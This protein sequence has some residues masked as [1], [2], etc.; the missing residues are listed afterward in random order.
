MSL[1]REILTDL[2]DLVLLRCLFSSVSHR[3]TSSAVVASKKKMPSSVSVS[4]GVHALPQDPLPIPLINDS[5]TFENRQLKGLREM[6]KQTETELKLKRRE[7][8]REVEKMREEFLKLHR[9]D[10]VWGS[11]ELLND[12]LVFKRRGSTDI[13]NSK[14]MKTLIT[15][16]PDSD[17]RKFRLRFDL[18]GFD[19]ES[20]RVTS[21][22]ER[23]IV[24]A[25]KSEEGSHGVAVKKEYNRKIQKP[26]DVEATRLKSRLTSD[27]IM[28]V[29]API[30][31]KVHPAAG[32]AP[33]SRKTGPSP[34]HSFHGSAR[35]K[36][37]SNT[38]PSPLKELKLGIPTFKDEENGQRRLYLM[39][40][41]GKM[42]K[43]KDITIQVIKENRILIKAKHEER[44]SER[45][46][47]NKFSKEFE[48]AEK[49]EAHSIRGG[50][51]V[52]G[53]LIVGA[54]VKGF[55]G[56]FTKEN[57]GQVIIEVIDPNSDLM[58]C[59]ILNLASFPPTMSASAV[60]VQP[61]G[62]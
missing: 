8:E 19:P 44:T 61:N 1:G 9:S 30:G 27:G 39:I 12:P 38:P 53:H 43:P 16:N 52:D 45:L 17:H 33:S 20:V 2:L 35:S 49:I 57:A 21:D 4:S 40:D 5:L 31:S 37:P 51:T 29:E 42:F 24:R 13:L 47:K 11:D 56:E 58:P 10:R 3:E 41:I 7:L 25:T 32:A 54:F 48:L 59:N 55:G 22:N 62:S 15:D 46:S 23:I 6:E 18:T 60:N 34:S 50:F 26:K 14:K 28:V 36:S